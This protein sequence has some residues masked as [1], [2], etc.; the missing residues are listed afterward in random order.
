MRA[1]VANATELEGAPSWAEPV[2]ARNEL[3]ACQVLKETLVTLLDA[4]PTSDEQDEELLAGD[5][6]SLAERAAVR[7]RLREK[8]LLLNG[9]N[10][11][12]HRVRVKLPGRKFPLGGVVPA[13]ENVSP[14]GGFTARKTHY[15]GDE[16]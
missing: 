4:Y 5:T 14:I 12:A 7:L 13:P 9:L 16:L 10:A 8:L 11:V 1:A 3:A 6:L 15:K 2:S